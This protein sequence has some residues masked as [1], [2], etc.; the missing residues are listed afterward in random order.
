MFKINR[1]KLEISLVNTQRW[2]SREY[3][4]GNCPVYLS[5]LTV[6]EFLIREVAFRIEMSE[7]PQLQVILNDLRLNGL[8]T[9]YVTLRP[10]F[11]AK[12]C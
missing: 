10:Q 1:S 9:I 8:I 3:A 12:K 2:E 7:L 6:I 5:Q 11:T 4:D